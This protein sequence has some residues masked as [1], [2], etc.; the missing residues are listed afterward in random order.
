ME[1][2]ILA[3]LFERKQKKVLCN[4]SNKELDECKLEQNHASDDL[5]CF[6]NNR[7]HPDSQKQLDRLI[8][9]YVKS[10][11]KYNKLQ[12]K[13]FYKMGIIDGLNLIK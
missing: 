7:V 11:E 9:N 1:D 3:I 13:E 10:K 12:N 6:I 4:I 2:G 5:L 8:E